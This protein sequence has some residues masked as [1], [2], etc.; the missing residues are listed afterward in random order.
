ML[1]VIM[2]ALVGLVSIRKD[3][4]LVLQEARESANTSVQQF[5]ELLKGNF[6]SRLVSIYLHILQVG[7]TNVAPGTRIKDDNWDISA[8]QYKQLLADLPEHRRA[9]A[10][11][12]G[13]LHWV[14]SADG[15]LLWPPPYSPAPTPVAD[16]PEAWRK[17]QHGEFSGR[18]I[19]ALAQYAALATNST[20][21]W[22]ETG[23]PVAPLA[24][25]CWLQ[26]AKQEATDQVVAAA[27]MLAS[28]A[29]NQPSILSPV[30]LREAAAA[31]SPPPGTFGFEESPPGLLANWAIAEDARAWHEY[32]H[33]T[34][35]PGVST[36]TRY[37][38]KDWLVIPV[39][40]RGRSETMNLQAQVGYLLFPELLVRAPVQEHLGS[41]QFRL[42]Q[43]AGLQV[44]LNDRELMAATGEKLAETAVDVDITP[45]GTQF[46]KYETGKASL[47]FM[48]SVY[49]TNPGTLYA[50]QRQRA[51]WFGGLIAIAC[52]VSLLGF[53]MSWSAFWRQ[54]ALSEQKSNFVSSVSHEL[55]AP[56]ASVRLMAENLEHGK[57]SEPVKQREYFRFIV[58]ECRRLSSLVENVLDF[59][60]I[61]QNRKQYDFEPTNVTALVQATVKLMELY[62]AEKEVRLVLEPTSPDQPAADIEWWLDGHALQQA[63]VNLIDNAIKHSPRGEVVTV[64]MKVENGAA[65]K[66]NLFVA[67]HGP[68]IPRAEHGKIFERFYRRGSELRRET[69]GVGIG[70]SIVKHIVAAHGGTVLVAS[71]TGN[72]SRF[73]IQ[74]PFNHQDTKAPRNEI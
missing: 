69:P 70:L 31:Y 12:A 59:S 72:G 47:H 74:I 57:I 52:F 18:A 2:L 30:F 49:L 5:A 23:I 11:W 45:Y 8:A 28:N 15:R 50:M 25:Y 44:R 21:A 56:I 19:E 33:T 73:T 64:G 16:V 29:F 71:E 63:L 36:W 41:P 7:S 68:G 58:Q 1:P 17:L 40:V 37:A 61:E 60:R 51:W 43:F 10:A 62:A 34:P 9:L 14:E 3:R 27:S 20:E 65:A 53:A 24:A 35:R 4:V 54:I 48:V 66:L 46:A 26:L 38:G 39:A 13:G 22:S 67:D 6:E 32:W 55:R 42:P